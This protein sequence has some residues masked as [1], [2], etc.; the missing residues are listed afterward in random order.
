MQNTPAPA[1]TPQREVFPMQVD[2][3]IHTLHTSSPV[4]DAYQQAL[5]QI[6]QRQQESQEAPPVREMK[7]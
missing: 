6:P 1:S 2:V 3:K 5:N 4:L 7:M